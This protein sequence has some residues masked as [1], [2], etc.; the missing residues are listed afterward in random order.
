MYYSFLR[1]HLND[2][3]VLKKI[4][5]YYAEMVQEAKVKQNIIHSYAV[6]GLKI[7]N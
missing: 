5:L 3:S 2:F 6:T 7:Q 1:N 4:L